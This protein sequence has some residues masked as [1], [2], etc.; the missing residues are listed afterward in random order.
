MQHYIDQLDKVVAWLIITLLS[1]VTF[2][3][4]WIFK[5]ILASIDARLDRQ[6]KMLEKQGREIMEANL[7][8]ARLHERFFGGD[9]TVERRARPRGREE[10]R[11]LPE[12]EEVRG[13][14]DEF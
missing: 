4:G 5:R 3:V 1:A 10:I 2:L 8:L 12:S 11:K 14:S 7:F 13:S 9:D 6:D